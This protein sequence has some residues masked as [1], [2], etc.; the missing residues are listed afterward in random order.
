VKWLLL[1]LGR[2]ASAVQSVIRNR[3]L[4]RAELAFLAFNVAE[5]ATWI[6]ILVYAFDRGGTAAAGIVTLVLLA[7]AAVVAPI[8]AALGDRHSRRRVVAIGYTL[9]AGATAATGIAMVADAP[10]ILVYAV[11]T[12][13]M[14]TY[15]TGRPG[16]HSLLPKLASSPDE[17]AAANSVSSLV[18]GLGGTAGTAGVA[19]LLAATSVGVAYLVMAAILGLGALLAYGVRVVHDT[20]PPNRTVG[21]WSFAVDA[22][23]GL[24]AIARVRGAGALLTVA[25]AMALVWGTFDV[26]LV[27]LAFD[28]L[29]IGAAGVGALHTSIAVGVL[30]GATG[31]VALVGRSRISPTLLGGAVVMGASIAVLGFGDTVAAAVLASGVAGAATT[32]L[33]VAGRTLLQRAIDDSLLARVFGAIESLWMIGF[34]VGGPVAAAL[35]SLFGLSA[36]FVVASAVVPLI[37]LLGFRA[38]DR[39]EQQVVVPTRQLELI[40]ALPM[41]GPLPKSDVERVARQLDRL[42]V[43]RGT[44]VIRQGDVGDRFYVVDAGAFEVL[45]DGRFVASLSE[46]DH[47]GEIAL[48][49]DVLRTATV[50]ATVDSTVWA[51]DQEEF[52]ATVTG[53]PQAKRAAH[54]ISA[55]RLRASSR[56]E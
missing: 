23:T 6:A 49:K 40:S 14:A 20:R 50:R 30:L 35:V 4:R 2:P 53:M 27:T 34:G 22:V 21:P 41:F 11:A 47:F 28:R 16:H 18:E 15:T 5:P 8:A 26:L 51:L 3:D 1:R 19:V 45:T 55:E 42:N 9:Q 25:A 7:P 24:L 52:L 43:V 44:D 36:S 46:G 37:T 33:D 12:I 10:A 17:L 56:P 48:L 32:V 29:G 31:S 39:L 38:L 13:A 54:A